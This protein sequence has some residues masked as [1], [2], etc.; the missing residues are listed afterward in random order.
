MERVVIE[1]SKS[2]RYLFLWF[3]LAF[4][5]VACMWETYYSE[6]HL[7]RALC[8]VSV[9]PVLYALLGGISL[10]FAHRTPL[11]WILFFVLLAWVGGMYLRSPELYFSVY[12]YGALSYAGLFMLLNDDEAMLRSFFQAAY[13]INLFFAC[14]FFLPIVLGDNNVTQLYL[15]GFASCAALVFLTSKYHSNRNTFIA[16]LA[17][18]LA[19]LVA[20][21]TAR[22]NLMLTFGLYI[23][24]GSVF[25][26][27]SGKIKSMET[28]FVSIV[29]GFAC[30]CAAGA[31]YLSQSSGMFSKLAGRATE[32][33]REEVFLYFAMDMSNQ[34]DILF[35]RGMGGTYYAPNVDINDQTGV[36][37]EDRGN[38]E[39]S[40]LQCILKG[41]AVYLVLYLAI[42]LAGMWKGFRAPNMLCRACACILFV[43]LVDMAPFGL[44]AFNAKTFMIWLALAICLN[45][46]FLKKTD[47]EVTDT[48]F[49]V[50]NVLLPWQKK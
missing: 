7:A 3:G 48:L 31:F 1:D 4:Y 24:L 40:Y 5:N 14:T 11:S 37:N 30:V 45:E 29:F 23:A 21:L 25:L 28:R 22:R 34:N 16:F 17:L 38:I 43:Q 39:C 50:K 26:L 33:T 12:C 9:L 10:K 49:K 44:H 42:F 13:K 8:L 6:H 19:F 46:R 20:V 2:R 18:F 41:G 36:E 47:T 35:G 15:E 27:L 32:N